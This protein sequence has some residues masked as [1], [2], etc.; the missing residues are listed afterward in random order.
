MAPYPSTNQKEK[1]DKWN[2]II[3]QTSQPAYIWLVAH[4]TEENIKIK[5]KM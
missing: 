3:Q 5:I 2:P 1:K 4:Q